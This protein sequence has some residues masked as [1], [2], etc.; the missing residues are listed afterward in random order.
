[1]GCRWAHPFPS[2]LLV[3]PGI[4]DKGASGASTEPG[5]VRLSGRAREVPPTASLKTKENLDDGGG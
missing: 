2:S 4:S 5:T 1:M 3:T